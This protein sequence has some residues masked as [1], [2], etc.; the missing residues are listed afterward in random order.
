MYNAIGKAS[1]IDTNN[2]SAV[3]GGLYEGREY[4]KGINKIYFYAC[5]S[6]YIA[7]QY[8]SYFFKLMGLFEVVV[9]SEASDV[10]EHDLPTTVSHN[11]PLFHTSNNFF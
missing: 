2:F 10:E 9:V 3:L 5:G 7:C 1:R 4:F 8:A 11:P 6:S